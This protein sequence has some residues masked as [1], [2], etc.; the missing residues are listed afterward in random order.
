LKQANPAA[1]CEPQTKLKDTNAPLPTAARRRTGPDRRPSHPGVSR[2][3]AGRIGATAVLSFATPAW[4]APVLRARRA[5]PV[6][7][8][9]LVEI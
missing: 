5:R 3:R 8:S 1:L 7:Q 6:L 9:R 4:A 2:P